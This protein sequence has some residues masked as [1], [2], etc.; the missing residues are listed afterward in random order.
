MKFRSR[1]DMEEAVMTPRKNYDPRDYDYVRRVEAIGGEIWAWVLATGAAVLFGFLLLANYSG[2]S[3]TASNNAPNATS[4]SLP[5]I[6]PSTPGSGAQPEKPT[7]LIHGGPS[8]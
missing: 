7:P 3:N 8:R 6:G 4:N 5:R 1:L 2:T